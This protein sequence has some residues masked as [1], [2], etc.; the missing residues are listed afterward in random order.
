M[1]CV[2]SCILELRGLS[3][4]KSGLP[5]G[6]TYPSGDYSPEWKEFSSRKSKTARKKESEKKIPH[7]KTPVQTTNVN[8]K[9][10]L[11]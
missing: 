3:I 6:C 9:K 8:L 4:A 7:R 2:P 1:V 11:F 5:H 10:L